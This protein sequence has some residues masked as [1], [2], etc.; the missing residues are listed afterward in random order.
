MTPTSH[1]YDKALVIE[2]VTEGTE[3]GREG[4]STTLFSTMIPK[5]LSFLSQ[6]CRIFCSLVITRNTK[7]LDMNSDV[8]ITTASNCSHPS[9]LIFCMHADCCA[10]RVLGALNNQDSKGK[11]KVYRFFS[12]SRK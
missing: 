1:P 3:K 11:D 9:R 5:L 6:N 4:K 7:E 12:S 10:R 8:Q 2:Q